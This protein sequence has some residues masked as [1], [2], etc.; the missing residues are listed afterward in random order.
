MI[1]IDYGDDVNFLISD[2]KVYVFGWLVALTNCSRTSTTK[3]NSWKSINMA[4]ILRP[5]FYAA[6]IG[7]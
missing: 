3:I 6:G 7:V 2:G 1:M 4:V 5:E